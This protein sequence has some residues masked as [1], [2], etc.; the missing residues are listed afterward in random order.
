MFTVKVI[1]RKTGRPVKGVKV[2]VGFDGLF[3]GFTKDEYTDYDGE[4]HFD[5]DNGTGTIYVK[6][7][8]EYEGKIEG[9]KVIYIDD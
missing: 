1:D 7:Q 6:G 4:V 3:R 2:S 5:N 8:R 9:R